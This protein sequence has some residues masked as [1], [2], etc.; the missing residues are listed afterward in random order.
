MTANLLKVLF[1]KMLSSSFN[2]ASHY[3]KM[4]DALKRVGG[5]LAAAVVLVAY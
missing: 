1:A 5:E 2:R 4:H 3:Q